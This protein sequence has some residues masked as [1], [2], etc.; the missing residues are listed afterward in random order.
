[1]S[2]LY[3]N[4]TTIA[5]G[6]MVH[7]FAKWLRGLPLDRDLTLNH[8]TAEMTSVALHASVARAGRCGQSWLPIREIAD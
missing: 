5:A 6:L 2:D 1:M 7:Q 4:R 8:L 3:S